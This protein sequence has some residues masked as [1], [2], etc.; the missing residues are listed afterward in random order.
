MAPFIGQ[1][2]E[3]Y[4]A[5]LQPGRILL[6]GH[7]HQAWPDVAEGALIEAFRDA[8]GHVDDKWGLAMEKAERV[9]ACVA[10]YLGTSSEEIALAQNTHEL[11]SRFLSALD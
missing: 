1:I 4:S 2:R 5:F 10:G 9:R 11:A 3:K 8:A 6:T 7:S